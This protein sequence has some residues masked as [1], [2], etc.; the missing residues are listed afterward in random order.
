ME[1]TLYDSPYATAEVSTEEVLRAAN[2]LNALT[3]VESQMKFR[4]VGFA[5]YESKEDFT[6]DKM[7]W[8]EWYEKKKCNYSMRIADSL[9]K[10]GQEKLP[11]YH[12]QIVLDSLN[13]VWSNYSG[14]SVK[15]ADSLFHVSRGLFWPR[16][17]KA[18]FES[19]K[20]E[21]K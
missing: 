21:S 6:K 7:K 3:R 14:D 18:P 10:S 17:L 11:E 20:R 9:F 2:C 15:I 4:E 16:F 13:R 8:I 19:L 5:V 1:S 12:S